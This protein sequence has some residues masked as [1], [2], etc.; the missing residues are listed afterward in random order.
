MLKFALACQRQGDKSVNKDGS[1]MFPTQAEA[2]MALCGTHD[3]LVKFLFPLTPRILMAVAVILMM[4]T[5][6]PWT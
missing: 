1:K 2:A 4:T 3:G 5:L 6:N